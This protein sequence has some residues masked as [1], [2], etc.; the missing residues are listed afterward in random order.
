MNF[1]QNK[2]NF[3]GF[4][5]DIETVVSNNEGDEKNAQMWKNNWMSGQSFGL[6]DT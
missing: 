3:D 1:H 6:I 4:K 5:T 2:I